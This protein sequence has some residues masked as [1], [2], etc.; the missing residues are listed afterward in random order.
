MKRGDKLMTAAAERHNDNQLVQHL[1]SSPPPSETSLQMARAKNNVEC[2]RRHNQ[3]N[4]S[5]FIY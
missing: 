5:E 3:S 1:I 2:C 4:L